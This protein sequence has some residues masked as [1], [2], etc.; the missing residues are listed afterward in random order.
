[1]R[2]NVSNRAGALLIFIALTL[3]GT[4]ARAA[5]YSIRQLGAEQL[6]LA[7]VAYRIGAADA[8]ACANPHMLSGLVLHDLT[9]Y[10]QPVRAAVS[11][12][13]SL[14]EG[15]GVL[16]VVPSSAAAAAGL[17]ID[18]EIVAL[19]GS[20]LGDPKA[21]SATRQS[22][23]RLGR[24]LEQLGAAMRASDVDLVVR[25]NGRM[26]HTTLRGQP[27]CGGEASLVTS[28]ALNAWSDG[29]RVFVSSAMMRLAE[30]DDELAFVVGHEMAHNILGHTSR[31]THGLL[32]LFGV[33]SA[34]ARREESA[35]DDLALP[36]MS[37]ANY[38][39]TSAIELLSR[40]QRALWWAISLDHPSFGSRIRNVRLAVARGQ[41][42]RQR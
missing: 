26:F 40:A 3:F 23:D 21:I 36:L 6:R 30:T 35:A 41:L 37:A 33:G 1:M 17:R 22:Y 28:S 15:V 18:D 27:A 4:V 19:N 38:R 31:D 29:R 7:T 14:H 32:S 11:T 25:R 39:P 16:A 5:P 24:F 9:Q 20:S 34:R 12:A 13:F 8:R 10:Q 2:G 42:P